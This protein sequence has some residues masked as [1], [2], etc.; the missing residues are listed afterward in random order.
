M[1]DYNSNYRQAREK[2]L[3]YQALDISVL[4]DREAFLSAA[5][6]EDAALYERLMTLLQA[7]DRPGDPFNPAVIAELHDEQARLAI[8]LNE[9]VQLLI[10]LGR[11]ID[12]VGDDYELIEEIGRGAT[13]VVYRARQKSLNR[14][15]AVKILLGSTIVSPKVRARFLA[16]AEAAAGLEHPQIVPIY[17]I[18]RHG[19]YDFYS[20]A[21]IRGGTLADAIRRG[22]FDRR[23]AVKLMLKVTRAV[24]YAH[25]AGVIHRDLKPDNILMDEAGQPN[26]SDFGLACR[27][28]D[29]TTQLLTG[30]IHGTPQ[31]MAPEQAEPHGRPVTMAA[32]IYSL[33]V[34]L[35][36][37]ITG[38][39]PLRSDS[40]ARTLELVRYAEPLAP[41]KHDRSIDRDLETVTMKCLEKQPTRRYDSAKALADDLTA[42]L[43]NRPIAARPPGQVERLSRLAQRHPARLMFALMGL[44][45]AITLG[46][47]GPV[48]A[49]HQTQLR[50]IA[51]TER[52]RAE[53]ERLAADAAKD[54]ADRAAEMNRRLAY[55]YSNRLVN[56]ITG[57]RPFALGAHHAILRTKTPLAGK[58]DLRGWEWYYNY[59]ATYMEPLRVPGRGSVQNVSFSPSGKQL[60][61]AHQG[62][63]G[64]IIRDGMH[65][66]TIRHLPDPTGPHRQV[67]WHGDGQRIATLSE[68]GMIR[69]WDTRDGEQLAQLHPPN[70]VLWISWQPSAGRLFALT[71]DD[72]FHWWDVGDLENI[73]PL[74]SVRATASGLICAALS[75][76]GSWVAAIGE[77]RQVFVWSA[78]RPDQKPRVLDGHKAAVT[79]LRW[80]NNSRWLAT[81]S[82]DGH[83]RVWEVESGARIARA[84]DLPGHDG[85]VS[86]MAWETHGFRLVYAQDESVSLHMV[87][88]PLSLQVHLVWYKD[89][90]KITALD[91]SM[92]THT[93]AVGFENGMLELRRA[94][95]PEAKR[96]HH[97]EMGPVQ[98]LAFSSDSRLIAI[99][100][101]D[102]SVKTQ[103]V[104]SND[105][106]MEADLHAIG[107][108]NYFEWDGSAPHRLMV[109][110][111][112]PTGSSIRF[113]DAVISD[114][115]QPEHTIQL[116]GTRAI[117]TAMQPEGNQVALLTAAGEIALWDIKA[118]QRKQ[119]LRPPD[120]VD[121]GRAALSFSPD[122]RYLLAT[123]EHHPLGAWDTRQDRP[124]SIERPG[125]LAPARTHAWHPEGHRFAT[126]HT[127]GSIGIWSV[128]PPRIIRRLQGRGESAPL[129]AWHPG[130]ERLASSAMA[131]QVRIWAWETGESPLSLEGNIGEITGLAW[132]PDGLRLASCN[133]AN[134]LKIWDASAGYLMSRPD[135]D[136]DPPLRIPNKDTG[137][138]PS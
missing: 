126:G 137:N 70:R 2:H 88:L 124:L 87:D 108:G 107:K 109:V 110:S 100:L 54:E 32:D 21:L 138:A 36:E 71:D 133:A 56:A 61:I 48:V 118:R 30:S 77:G 72:V 52:E 16:E 57:N 4:A 103:I 134:H 96:T 45:L 19:K 6:G 136:D 80:H 135:S 10:G 65:T 18:G 9:E 113:L 49:W 123:G 97:Y 64:S 55:A 105:L 62:R 95:L 83:L 119:V 130:G 17:D 128:D 38:A 90:Q 125:D 39:P 116:P 44:L 79:G 46:I 20:M 33:G 114:E 41:R 86:A 81:R 63:G 12:Q 8:E 11:G 40:T 74:S 129:L 112:G 98:D 132:S 29:Q 13:A 60:A 42:W 121:P 59:A 25:Q 82:R 3:F 92:M 22:D 84:H 78:D 1:P 26:I 51:D 89:Q 75:P 15:V 115:Q 5:C 7:A 94:G 27:L 14:E 76:D 24:W 34:I 66:A 127:D 101:G 73:K 93:V 111:D 67:L 28:D 35:Y 31:Y 47:G 91:W 43:D 85:V 68:Q 99:R 50:K 37:M 106:L 117:A 120:G 53:Q 23:G 122:G 102:G 104:D 69:F 58:E 131:N